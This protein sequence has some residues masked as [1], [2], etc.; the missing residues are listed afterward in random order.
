LSTSRGTGPWG[1]FSPLE[2]T[3]SDGKVPAARAGRAGHAFFTTAAASLG[4]PEGI[5]VGFAGEGGWNITLDV[6]ATSAWRSR[7]DG[8]IYILLVAQTGSFV[9]PIVMMLAVL[10]SSACAASGFEPS[11]GGRSTYA[12]PSSSPP[13][14]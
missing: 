6:F 11:Y 12:D 5:R 3:G 4:G 13:P 2:L 8:G 7:R 10:P 1:A 14:A 9:I